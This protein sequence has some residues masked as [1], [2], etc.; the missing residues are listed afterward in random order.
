LTIRHADAIRAAVTRDCVQLANRLTRLAY[1][2]RLTDAEIA[3][4]AGVSRAQLN[5]IRNRRAVPRV[6]TALA[7]ASALSCRVG[8]LFF[9][10]PEHFS[11]GRVETADALRR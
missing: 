5:R 8:D 1:R 3:A 2:R 9:L 4:R 7:L 10:E 11:S 6:R